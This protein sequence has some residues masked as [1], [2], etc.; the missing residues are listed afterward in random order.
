MDLKGV[1]MVLQ[2]AIMKLKGWL[3][4]LGQGAAMDLKGVVMVL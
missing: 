4:S 3:A 2:G 1:F